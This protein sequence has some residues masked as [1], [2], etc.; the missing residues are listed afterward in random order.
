[1]TSIHQVSFGAR[2]WATADGHIP[3][4]SHGEAPEML[5]H[6]ALCFLNTGDVPANVTITVYFSDRE[7]V[8]PY[9]VVVDPRRTKHV[10]LNDLTDPEPI[11]A[12]V[13]FATLVE[14]D[15]PV[16]VQQTRLDSRQAENALI[17]TVAYTNGSSL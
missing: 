11:P 15:V 6:E 3:K 10:R 7:P 14:S 13:D 2:R 17:S 8:G 9:E 4:W 12:G 1:M 5:S 16:V